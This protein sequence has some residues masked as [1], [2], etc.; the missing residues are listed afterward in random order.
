MVGPRRAFALGV[1][2]TGAIAVLITAR[3]VV[4][5]RA[6]LQA[7]DAAR[8]SGDDEG[9]RWHYRRAARWHAPANPYCVEALGRLAE[10]AVAAEAA[11]DREAAL[12]NW[13]AVRAAVVASR[14]FYVP[15]RALLTQA[16]ERLARLL[17]RTSV[18]PFD[19]RKSEESLRAEHRALLAALP[20]PSP[21]WSWLVL[22]G[23]V[24]WVASLF[25]L[26]ARAID[27]HDRVLRDHA[28]RWGGLAA[29]GLLLFALG[30]S[31]A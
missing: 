19:A 30:L 4:G 10:M 1:A 20:R 14:S 2:V 25:L 7:G 24:V 26:A 22:L 23:F 16:T 31:R 5:S 9:A 12:A 13:R 21:G 11:G 3:V 17:A 28:L 27:A 8:R 29:L 6:E 18:P 15:H